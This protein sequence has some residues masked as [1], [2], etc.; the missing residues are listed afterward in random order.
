[1]KKLLTLAS[2][3][4]AAVVLLSCNGTSD[5]GDG[6]VTGRTLKLVSDKNLIQ[7]FDGDYATLTVTLD[8]VPVTEGVTFF[9]GN[10]EVID[11][12]DFKFAS[13]KVGEFRI[14]ANYGTLNSDVISIKAI[15]VAIPDTPEDPQESSTDFKVRVLLTE[16]TTVGCSACPSMKRILHEMEEDASFADNLVFT[17]SHT[18]L[19]GGVA[20][21]CYLHNR[22]FEEFC[23]ITGYPTVKLDLSGTYNNG[24]S[25]DIKSDVSQIVA[26]KEKF[27]PGIAVNSVLKDDKVV[28]KVT[29]KAKETSLYRV[30]AFLV[31]DGVYAVQN[32]AGDNSWM[33]THD[34]VIRYVDAQYKGSFYGIPVAEIESGRT[35]DIMFSWILDDIWEEGSDKGAVNGGIAWPE[36]DNSRLHMVV[37]VSM[38]DGQGGYVLANVADC[39][40]NGQTP[41]QYR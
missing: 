5:E 6:T 11:L 12:P 34:N 4:A 17:E 37:F 25:L 15:D 26:A 41:Y 20:D 9:D 10:N 39:P 14:W 21:P 23:M 18:G 28:A 40:V 16:F 35:G 19:V 31:E 27:A 7:T 22:D 32:N 3:L 30:G 13:D 8:G 33:H 38:S 24:N 1:M 36:R 2:L 29:V